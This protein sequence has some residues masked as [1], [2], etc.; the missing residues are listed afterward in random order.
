[1][2]PSIAKGF[3]RTARVLIAGGLLIVLGACGFQ[4]RGQ[5]QVP[6]FLTAVSL[7][8]PVSSEALGTEL[9]LALER[10]HIE[11]AG[12]EL[13]LQITRESLTRQTATVDSRAKAAEYTLVYAVDYRLLGADGKPVLP[14]Q[15]VILRRNYQYDATNVVGKNTEEEALTQELRQDAARQIVRQISARRP[16]AAE[17]TPGPVAQP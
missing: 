10:L 17:T 2:S 4:L 6:A 9:R 7:N 3:Y 16:T 1:M 5:Y 11:P 15:P 14:P 13:V 12:G 8:V